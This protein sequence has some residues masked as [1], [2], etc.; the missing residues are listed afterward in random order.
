MSGAY[1]WIYV[2]YYKLGLYLQRTTL[3]APS[4]E[5]FSVFKYLT[6]V[7]TSFYCCSKYSP[8]IKCVSTHI[9][10][11]ELKCVGKTI[12]IQ[13][14]SCKLCQLIVFISTVHWLAK[15]IFGSPHNIICCTMSDNAR[16]KRKVKL[17]S[18]HCEKQTLVSPFLNLKIWWLIL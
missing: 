6:H 15:L 9:S 14:H 5:L 16:G 2:C 3:N 7:P 11:L 18:V 12:W 1:G 17:I 4:L 13:E 8:D 10:G